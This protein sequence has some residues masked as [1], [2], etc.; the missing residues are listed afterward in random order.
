M[1]PGSSSDGPPPPSGASEAR[2]DLPPGTVVDH[3]YEVMRVL[4]RGGFAT[5]YLARDRELARDV[6]LKVLHADLLDSTALARLR[7]E[8]AVAREVSEKSL[9]HIYDFGRDGGIAYLAMEFV[10]GETLA[11][12]IDRAGPLAIEPVV[13]IARSVLL[14]LQALH[15]AGIVHR[16]VK[17]SNIL[18]PVSGSAKLGDLGLIHRIE[19]GETVATEADT[20]LGTIEYLSPEQL[21]G[22]DATPKSDLY[23]LGV[24]LYEAL[25]G[26]LPFPSGDSVATAL[27]R[28]SSKPRELTK[29]Q[30][31][32]PPWL[33]RIVHKLLERD[34]RKRYPNPAAALR[35]LEER[36]QP[37][38]RHRPRLFLRSILLLLLLLSL[39]G[40][41]AARTLSEAERSQPFSHLVQRGS[42]S[43]LGIAKNGAVLW[44]LEGIQAPPSTF[45]PRPGARLQLAASCGP[46]PLH[47]LGRI[48]QLC[49]FD[50]Q[51]GGLLQ[52]V[53]LPTAAKLFP[54]FG[55]SYGDRV[56]SIDLDGD[57]GDELVVT[58]DQLP[59]WPSYTV[60]YEPKIDRARVVLVASGHHNFAGAVDLDGDGRK[61]LIFRGIN[62]LMGWNSGLAAVRLAPPVNRRG[63]SPLRDAAA[64]PDHLRTANGTRNLLWYVL[65]PS[66]FNPSVLALH[67]TEVDR[68]ARLIR[69]ISPADGS[70]LDVGFDGFLVTDKSSLP[71][72]RRRALRQEAYAQLRAATA[73]EAAHAMPSAIQH[74]AHAVTLARDANDSLLTQW[75]ERRRGI[76]FV[77]ADRYGDAQSQFNELWQK[78]GDNNLA[79]DAGKA[80]FLNGRPG[81]ALSWFRRGLGLRLAPLYGR[82][83][84]EFINGELFSLWAL[85]RPEA[86]EQAARQAATA[87]PEQA[88]GA[89]AFREFVRWREG[90][91]PRDISEIFGHPL[92]ASDTDLPRYW[93][94]EFRRSWGTKPSLLLP[95]IDREI[96]RSTETVPLLLS[97][98]AKILAHEG[99]IGRALRIIREAVSEADTQRRTTMGIRA[100][101][102]LIARR[103]ITIAK[104]AGKPSL[105]H[106]AS[107][108]R[109]RWAATLRGRD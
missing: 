75:T 72:K 99:K 15:H 95:A 62:N 47:A 18:L 19:S 32:V 36:P 9:V 41:R 64:S 100:Q 94:L 58:F 69:L 4:G 57:G 39:L 79:Y 10:E 67:Y 3:R 51:S 45:R 38:F 107:E 6:A 86:A 29:T 44:R 82:Q 26:Q 28:L 56:V 105:A 31:G 108:T 92:R 78:S 87:F 77:K 14:A 42:Y 59:L 76:A 22:D 63:S 21:R 81:L 40:W 102:D 65:I 83:P 46:P 91:K 97:L 80:F 89:L 17:P 13:S 104:L 24:V 43:Y 93:E 48:R 23:C 37:L 96:H 70:E 54:G 61:E 16:D 71:G 60:L 33:A 85:G 52:R 68:A 1:T 74:L 35:D 49:I 25:T 66:K 8:A 88:F 50:A 55:S 12:S 20:V 73:A 109:A 5:V 106:Q 2:S 101:A 103:M 90:R 98:K 30:P 34:P 53:K 11:Q 7:R 27:S 84:R